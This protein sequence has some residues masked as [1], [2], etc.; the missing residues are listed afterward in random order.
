MDPTSILVPGLAMTAVVAF[1]ALFVRLERSRRALR[2]MQEQIARLRDEAQQLRDEAQQLA[3]EKARLGT[4]M[5]ASREELERLR[6]ELASA[7]S[8]MAASEEELDNTRERALEAGRTKSL[9]VA[10]MSHELRTPLNGILGL[11]RNL[12]DSSLS[13]QQRNEVELIQA[14]GEDLVR[15]VNDVLDLSK[16]DA[17]KFALERVPFDLTEVLEGAFSLLYPQAERKRLTYGIS[18]SHRM[19][20]RFIGDPFRL[21]QVTLNLISNAIKFTQSGAV[22]LHAE[23]GELVAGAL[24]IRLQVE[25]TGIGIAPDKVQRIFNEFEQADLSTTRKF[26][27][28]GLGLSLSRR[29]VDLM[30]GEIEV[31]TQPGRGSRFTLHLPLVP[32]QGLPDDP[33]DPPSIDGLQIA[34]LSRHSSP[35]R[36]MTRLLEAF[37]GVSVLRF[38]TAEDLGRMLD[39]ASAENRPIDAVIS[40]EGS[41]SF[42]PALAQLT[43][44]RLAGRSPVHIILSPASAHQPSQSTRG[45]KTLVLHAPFLPSRILTLLRQLRSAPVGPLFESAGLTA[46]DVY[47]GIAASKPDLLPV[48]IAHENPVEL[49]LLEVMLQKLDRPF[50]SASGETE[51]L[52]LFENGAFHALLLH[53]RMLQ[54]SAIQALLPGNG[55]PD[56]PLRVAVVGEADPTTLDEFARRY[57]AFTHFRSSPRLSQLRDLLDA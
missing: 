36:V 2:E 6:S 40:E 46:F 19:P 18:Y 22:H 21:R 7:S 54:S 9:F 42:P 53:G 44:Q 30:G 20:R 31:E 35:I 26:G 33:Q 11:T 34:T 14:A 47:P 52:A 4:E 45:G 5:A 43:L 56:R 50:L 25:D 23:P 29:I 55:Q 32:V 1:I 15:I 37:P 38:D 3:A 51:L 24:W 28:T 39:A 49:R 16:L 27:G 48:L 13:P 41:T 17:G 8:A 10:N 57:P 12:L